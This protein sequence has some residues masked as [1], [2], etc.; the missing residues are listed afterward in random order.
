MITQ[1]KNIVK[2]NVVFKKI[3]LKI[4]YP[5][6]DPRPRWWIRNLINPFF[7]QVSKGVIVRKHS[8]LDIVPFNI[9]SIG[10]NSI[11]EDFSVVNNNVGFVTIG[12]DTIIGLN[13]TIIGPVSI[14]NKVMFAQNIVVSGLNHSYQDITLASRNQP[15]KTSL[16]TIEDEV[17]IG[18]NVV[19]TAGVTV[20]EHSVIAAGSVVTKDV[21]AF[22]VV[23]GNPAKVLKMYDPNT[24]TWVKPEAQIRQNHI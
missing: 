2:N 11:I 12:N 6:N 23:G 21:E 3:A 9:F 15:C 22:T 5:A 16:I 8:R 18:A 7:T 17:W 13:N 4:I 14:G 19:I 24:N 10:T 1:L 20:G